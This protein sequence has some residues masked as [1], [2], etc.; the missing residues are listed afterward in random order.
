MTTKSEKN[1]GL[2]GSYLEHSSCGIVP[3]VF[4]SCEKFRLLTLDH[5]KKNNPYVKT[6]I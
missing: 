1:K 2:K 6:A 4:N 5:D 3:S